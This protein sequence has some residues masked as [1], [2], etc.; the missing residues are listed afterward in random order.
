[1]PT[2]YRPNT[3]QCRPSSGQHTGLPAHLPVGPCNASVMPPD[4]V[5]HNHAKLIRVQQYHLRSDW[6]QVVI[7]YKGPSRPWCSCWLYLVLH[8]C[9]CGCGNIRKSV[10]KLLYSSV[11]VRLYWIAACSSR[12]GLWLV[13][14]GAVSRAAVLR[15]CGRSVGRIVQHHNAAG[16]VGAT[17]RPD[18]HLHARTCAHVLRGATGSGA[19]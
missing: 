13:W 4:H 9:E 3:P 19:H 2:G 1:M 17:H 11:F 7:F 15:C 10:W 5:S 16:L 6:G 8:N 18:A 14:C 12:V